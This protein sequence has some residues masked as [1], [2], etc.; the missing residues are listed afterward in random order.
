MIYFVFV[1][2]TRDTKLDEITSE[3]VVVKR[4]SE[5][6]VFTRSVDDDTRIVY[7]LSGIGQV[8][9]NEESKHDRAPVITVY[10]L[11]ICKHTILNQMI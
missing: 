2:D 1:F 4:G 5:V 3:E 11:N 10:L 9:V 8:E 7:E 6:L